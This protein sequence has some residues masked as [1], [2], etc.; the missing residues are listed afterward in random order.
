MLKRT[1]L[2]YSK[3]LDLEKG[4]IALV[5]LEKEYR[6]RS[7]GELS[8]VGQ[9]KRLDFISPFTGLAI[10]RTDNRQIVFRVDIKPPIVKQAVELSLQSPKRGKDSKQLEEY[11]NAPFFSKETSNNSDN[12]DKLPKTVCISGQN[13]SK[14]QTGQKELSNLSKLSD[15]GEVSRLHP[16]TTTTP[17]TRPELPQ[18]L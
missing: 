1:I 2:E 13:R 5:D 3:A 10:S 6:K 12:Y 4:Q 11:E 9:E 17:T 14:I 7:E 8:T 16:T 15:V 18:L